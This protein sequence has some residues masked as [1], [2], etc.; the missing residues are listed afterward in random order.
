M[1]G[2]FARIIVLAVIVAV[3]AAGAAQASGGGE[4]EE[5]KASVGPLL[6]RLPPVSAPILRNGRVR[7]TIN[8]VT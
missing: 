4:S 8:L 7:R 1:V 5:G 3:S 6:M 2:A